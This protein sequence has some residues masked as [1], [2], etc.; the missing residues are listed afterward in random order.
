MAKSCVASID[1]RLGQRFQIPRR[2]RLDRLDH[3]SPSHLK[4]L[5]M[6]KEEHLVLI[7][8]HFVL[9]PRQFVLGETLEWVHLPKGYAAYV[10]GR[11]SWGRCGLI[12]ATATGIHP[13][14][15]GVLTLEITNVGE[16][17][18][19]L[20]PGLTIAQLFIHEVTH[21]EGEQ[22]TPSPTSGNVKASNVDAAGP[23]K[24]IIQ[25]IARSRGLPNTAER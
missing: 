25:K 17:P 24:A 4:D 11:S 5:E 22:P 9:H 14:Y 12:I 23:D 3:F 18:L 19:Y 21:V 20:Y 7:G 8:D 1:V 10:N 15:S 6:Y 13:Y 2:A 16:I